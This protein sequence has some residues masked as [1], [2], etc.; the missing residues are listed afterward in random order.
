M[1][2][3]VAV[4]TASLLTPMTGVGRYTYNLFA[5]IAKRDD[6]DLD[7]TYGLPLGENLVIPAK[8][9]RRVSHAIKKVIPYASTIRRWAQKSVLES[10]L[11]GGKYDLYHEPNFL[12]LSFSVPVITTIHDL[13]IIKYPDYHPADRVKLFEKHLH[14]AIEQSEY[15]ITDSEF[16]KSE[17]VDVFGV[18]EEKVVTTLL[19]VEE[20][21]Y[22]RTKALLL[23]LLEKYKLK[24]KSFFLIVSTL[25]P[26]KNFKLAIEAYIRLDTKIKEQYPLVIVGMGGWEVSQ[27]AQDFEKLRRQGYL[28]LLGYVA[29]EELPMLYSA[30]KIFIYPSVYEGFGLPPL[31]AMACGTPVITSNVSSLPE[32]VDDAGIM[33]SP[34]DD[35]GLYEKIMQLLEDSVL[36]DD[37][38]QKSIERA[39]LFTWE[40]CARQTVDVYRRV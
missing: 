6:C 30:A 16:V 36:L 9:Y 15:L 19:G 11:K 3:K 39:K 35:V 20:D 29:N 31:E 40:K 18:N 17:M 8:H 26:R 10:K 34:H 32:V 33:V 28:R 38:S 25:E 5:E 2:L 12:P 13:S 23:P 22:P 4:N 27:F 24:Y 7:Y 37:L 21:F 14:R 1:R